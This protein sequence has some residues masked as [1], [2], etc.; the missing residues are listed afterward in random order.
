MALQLTLTPVTVAVSVFLIVHDL[1]FILITQ[2]MRM[3]VFLE[4]KSARG[5]QGTSVTDR[6]NRA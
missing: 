2:G 3:K 5:L 6:N 4:A 1:Q